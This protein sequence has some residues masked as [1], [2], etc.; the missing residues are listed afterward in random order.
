M[1]YVQSVLWNHHPLFLRRFW[2]WLFIWDYRQ[3]IYNKYACHGTF[4]TEGGGVKEGGMP[5]TMPG[6][7][8]MHILPDLICS[9]GPAFR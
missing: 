1:Y 3:S 2:N 7:S 8:M 4:I 6:H 5:D 9:S